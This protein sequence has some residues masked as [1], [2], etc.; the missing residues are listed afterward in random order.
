MQRH[1]LIGKVSVGQLDAPGCLQPPP[2]S[3]EPLRG[4]AQRFDR[5]I[6]IPATCCSWIGMVAVGTW[7]VVTAALVGAAAVQGKAFTVFW[8][9]DPDAFS[10]GMLQVCAWL[11][12]PAPQRACNKKRGP[13]TGAWGM[14]FLCASEVA[15]HLPRL[16]RR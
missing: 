6:S 13:A 12:V 4:A 11:R 8:L 9:P 5:R 2:P 15:F 16:C 7:V 1:V 3:A 14:L 10:G